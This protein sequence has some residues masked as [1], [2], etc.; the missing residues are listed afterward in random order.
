MGIDQIV[1]VLLGALAGGFVNGLTGFGTGITAMGL[2]LYA[3]SPSVAASL[4]IVCSFLSQLQ[5]LPRIW[6]AIQWKG[7]LPFIIPG[8]VGVPIG[9]RMLAYIDPRTFKIGVGVFL[10]SYTVYAL[11]RTERATSD[12][13]GRVGD[14]VIGFGGGCL[15]GL[16]GISGVPLIVWTDI[17]AYAKEHRRSILQ[18]F[19]TA[20]L[21]A[22]IAS[23]ALSGLLTAQ[24]GL[25]TL[26]ALP[27]TV[28]GAWL[29]MTVYQ[30][31]GNRGFQQ[32]VLALLFLSGVMLIWTSW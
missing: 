21:A 16:T 18:A 26:A 29:G 17:R 12:I 14:G 22:A 25:A 9:T 4:V 23:H 24:V 5:T 2:W 3:L 30:R 11:T 31:L 27:G 32:V 7:V 1:L 19:N 6:H 13:G 20:I 15:G 8:L 28:G 10:V